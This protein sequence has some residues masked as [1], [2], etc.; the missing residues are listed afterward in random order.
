MKRYTVDNN[1]YF[2]FQ[3]DAENHSVT[4]LWGK[5]DFRLSFKAS[6]EVTARSRRYEGFED[7]EG[8]FW[9]VDTLQHRHQD[10]WYDYQ[11]VAD[12]GFTFEEVEFAREEDR[13]FFEFPKN[14]MRVAASIAAEELALKALHS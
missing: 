14:L 7:Q 9:V 6:D 13:L 2:I 12:H 1:N 10:L 4:F 11:R 5:F 3:T 8:R